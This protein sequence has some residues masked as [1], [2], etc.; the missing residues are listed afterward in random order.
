MMIS[1][2]IAIKAIVWKSSNPSNIFLQYVSTCTWYG[3]AQFKVDK[4][5]MWHVLDTTPFSFHTHAGMRAL[6][7]SMT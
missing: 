2:T 6:A 4:V 1:K 3:T 7:R 5:H